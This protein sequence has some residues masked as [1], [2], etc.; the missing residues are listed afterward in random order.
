[1]ADF[2]ESRFVR[3]V[4]DDNMTKQPGNL[5]WMAPE[6]FTQHKRYNT[7][8]DVFSYALVLWELHTGERVAGRLAKLIRNR[9]TAVR[10]FETGGGRS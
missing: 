2:G 9:R 1:V 7:K 6:I 3:A 5:R 8:A 4:D 10:A